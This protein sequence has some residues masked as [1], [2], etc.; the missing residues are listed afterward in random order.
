MQEPGGQEGQ[1][2]GISR[3]AHSETAKP[4]VRHVFLLLLTPL[5]KRLRSSSQASAG[6]LLLEWP[7]IRGAPRDLKAPKG[8]F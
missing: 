8:G 5:V 2:K 7:E 4:G 3:T 6:W 1:L